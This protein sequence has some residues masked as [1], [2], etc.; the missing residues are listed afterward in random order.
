MKNGLMKVLWICL[1]VSMLW[2]GTALAAGKVVVVTGASKQDAKDV[3]TYQPVYDGIKE[4]LA[5]RDT[6][7]V[8]QYVKLDGAPDEATRVERGR[9]AAKKALAEN[10]DV[11][12]VLNDESVVYV[13]TQIK[14]TPVVFGY[15]FSDP[16]QL[17][18]PQDNVTGVTRRSF[19]PD[20][21]KLAR[22]VTGAETVGLISKD[23]RSMAGVKSY[24]L[25]GADKL[26]QVSGV[27]VEDVYLCDTFGEWSGLVN[28]WEHD[29]I[30]LADTSRIEKNGE[31]MDAAELVGWTVENAD[32]PVIGATERDT[33]AGAMFSIVTSEKQIGWQAGQM[34]AKI[35]DGT[36]VSDIPMEAGEKGKLLIN[37]TTVEKMGVDI[38]YDT[39]SSAEKI[40]E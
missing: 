29:L 28:N 24:I 13:A 38:P 8:F 2:T 27:R 7:I 36:P 3:G 1:A 11:V 5:Q 15:I 22:E 10:P 39:L 25:A 12:M 9:E 17:G 31:R 35:L 14:D 30:Y 32:V 16:E 21:W 23:S 4:A 18:L 40:Y 34:S 20:I 37:G 19:A 26:E 33:E 6:E